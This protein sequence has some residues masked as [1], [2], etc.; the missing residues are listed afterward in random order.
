MKTVL[1]WPDTARM[2]KQVQILDEGCDCIWRHYF[3]CRFDDDEWE[4]A[5]DLGSCVKRLI[6]TINVFKKML[7]EPPID[8]PEFPTD[9][10]VKE[11]QFKI[12]ALRSGVADQL[13]Q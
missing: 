2:R 12:A 7:K 3:A 13:P 10:E 5:D 11:F 4:I 9:Q 8:M 6:N 1:N